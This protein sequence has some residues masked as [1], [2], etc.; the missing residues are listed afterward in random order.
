MGEVETEELQLAGISE[1]LRAFGKC[2]LNFPLFNH[3]C[4][5]LGMEE[6]R[7]RILS[8]DGTQTCST[9]EV[10]KI[11]YKDILLVRPVVA[12]WPFCQQFLAQ[13]DL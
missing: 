6:N 10:W 2:S 3:T 7:S 4:K 1:G 13:R 5:V 11:W 8:Q 9:G 12:L